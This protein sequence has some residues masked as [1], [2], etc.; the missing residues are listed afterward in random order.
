M[1]TVPPVDVEALFAGF[2]RA[3]F[4]GARASQLLRYTPDL[5]DLLSPPAVYPW[6]NGYDRALNTEMLI[7]RAVRSIGGLSGDALATMLCLSPG[8]V[9]RPLTDR[10]RIAADLFHRQPRTFYRGRYEKDLL[11]DLAVE[12]YRLCTTDDSA[13]P[14]TVNT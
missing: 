8:L 1:T 4:Y 7:R 3:L 6:M 5:I 2:C 13:D 12:I 11:Y 14:P 10:R 9:G